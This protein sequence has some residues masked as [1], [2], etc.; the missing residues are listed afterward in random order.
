MLAI[1]S[2]TQT[3]TTPTP[4]T[5]IVTSLMPSTTMTSPSTVLT[6]PL[7]TSPLYPTVQIALHPNNPGL[8]IPSN[9]MGFSYEDTVLAGNYFNINNSVYINLL[10]N[11]GTG[12]L[13]FGGNSVEYTYWSRT[14]GTTFPN[15]KAVL[16][17][18]N[19]DQL[20]A[21]TNKTNWQ[22]IFGLNLGANNPAM[23]ADEAAYAWQVGQNSIIGFEIGNEPD[24]YPSNGLRASTYNYTDFQS[25]FDSYLQ[26]IRGQVPKAPIVGPDTAD[27]LNWFSDFLKDEKNNLALAS[28]HRYPLSANPALTPNDASYATID[29]LLS[30][31]TTQNT[32]NS[33]QQFES[34]AKANNIS[35]RYDETNS[36][37][38]GGKDGVSNVFASALWGADYLFDLAENGVV[39]ANFH[40]GFSTSNY[41]PIEFNNNQYTA[42]PL[43]YAMLLFHTVAQGKVVPVDINTNVNVT[44]H[45]VLGND[46]ALSLV[47]INKDA[48]QT[49]NAEISPGQLYGEA[50]A[51]RLT[52]PSLES[53]TGI[54]FAG[55]S[56]SAD[57]TWSPVEQEKVNKNGSDYQIVVPAA[58][59]VVVSFK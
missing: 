45:A 26:A 41:T 51:S 7:P 56:I 35:L 3:S 4:T 13:R 22:V 8:T 53:Q 36:A 38:S 48:N 27:N 32:I 39:G 12:V 16:T 18:T 57:G 15:A 17:P 31:A 37:S 34:A 44:A 5:P 55:S 52:A 47:I 24:L 40:G 59:A 42:M 50:L 29:K 20:F 19:L 1:S 33:I 54:T 46:G 9:F 30:A 58:S 49:V 43:Y 28:Q 11:L 14:L 25:D 6:T 23:A 21:F 10:N 2:T